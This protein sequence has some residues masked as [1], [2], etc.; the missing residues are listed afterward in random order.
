MTSGGSGG[1]RIGSQVGAW[2]SLA[3]GVAGIA[4]GICYSLLV[5]DANN[6][7][8]HGGVSPAPRRPRGRSTTGLC[9][10]NGKPSYPAS[11][12]IAAWMKQTKDNGDRYQI[13]QWIG[14]GVGG[15]LLATSAVFFYRGYLWRPSGATADAR[16]SSFHFAPL[17]SPDGVGA[18]AFTTF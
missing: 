6:N 15:V 1:S 10:S 2:L 17:F 18:M 14:Y 12:N 8:I 3:G 16:G 4:I 5:I 13:Y 7:S 11:C 9:D